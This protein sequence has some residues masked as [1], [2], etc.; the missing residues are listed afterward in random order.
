MS[1]LLEKLRRH[2]EKQ[3]PLHK[4]STKKT[5]HPYY[6]FEQKNNKNGNKKRIHRQKKKNNEMKK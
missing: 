3:K 2:K 6:P 1:L 5:K 4:I